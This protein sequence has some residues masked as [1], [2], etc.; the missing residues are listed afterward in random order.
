MSRQKILISG[1]LFVVFVASA[2]IY[3]LYQTFVFDDD[4]LSY[5]QFAWS[6]SGDR[7][8]YV[9]DNQATHNDLYIS[10]ISGSGA[11]RIA[12]YADAPLRWSPNGQ[13]LAFIARRDGS[14]DGDSEIYRV[15]ADGSN[16]INLTQYP[17]GDGSPSWSPDGTK[18]AF[19]SFQE[20]SFQIYVMG[21]DGTNRHR[22]TN[23]DNRVN[24]TPIWSPDGSK[25]AFTSGP[26]L[27][28]EGTRFI[29]VMDADGSNV[30]PLISV[31]NDIRY[32]TWSPDGT[33]IAFVQSDSLDNLGLYV[34]NISTS[35][36]T[37]LTSTAANAPIVWSPNNKHIAFAGNQRLQLLEID[38]MKVVQLH[39]GLVGDVHWLPSDD[40][41]AFVT[42]P[43][44]EIQT[45]SVD[46]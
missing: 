30:T 24:G 27:Y 28:Q 46:S 44:L 9:V 37:H 2:C 6:P 23:L 35:G 21:I 1:L 12:H 14:R 38:S 42:L 25:I 4:P 39:D 29:Y 3:S 5:R 17:K 33:R 15:D 8:A 11:I 18:I 26:G 40:Q 10:E 45:V 36:L 41:V 20:D 13:Y 34:L 7:F 43:Y 16:V 31:E 22:L 32:M 19:S